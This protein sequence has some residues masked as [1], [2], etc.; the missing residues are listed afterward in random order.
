MKEHNFINTEKYIERI[1][2][3]DLEIS[4]EN[5]SASLE[6]IS[7]PL[8]KIEYQEKGTEE[9]K[10]EDLD[11]KLSY[12]AIE[13]S[14]KDNLQ[15]Y[16]DVLRSRDWSDQDFM[17]PNS[18]KVLDSFTFSSPDGVIDLCE[19]ATSKY[20]IFF[21]PTEL[22]FMGAVLEN[23]QIICIIDDIT[24]PRAI[25]TLLHEIGHT[26]D[27]KNL[28]EKGVDKMV[29]DHQHSSKAEGVRR[30]RAATAFA[31]NK[32]RPFIKGE[33]KTDII[34]FLKYYALKHYY[35]SVKSD[36]SHER[37]SGRHFAQDWYETEDEY[38][39]L[40]D[41][42]TNYWKKTEAYRKWKEMDEY[43]NVEDWE[44]FSLWNEWVEKNN[45]DFY[46][47]LGAQIEE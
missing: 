35:D 39:V 19:I 31:L 41:T 42:F 4:E 6:R 32:L 20:K 3:S 13:V 5:L 45:Y 40:Y 7:K 36:L 37:Y 30:E 46:K 18:W 38:D 11:V 24:S 33:Q 27:R 10:V 17:N 29:T 23:P 28:E 26:W 8:H 2:N 9:F 15:V 34:N 14:D 22:E 47:D 43:K 1:E 25:A 21:C 16:L 44:E 12:S